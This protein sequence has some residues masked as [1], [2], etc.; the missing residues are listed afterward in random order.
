LHAEGRLG[1]PIGVGRTDGCRG[2]V[3]MRVMTETR[4]LRTR[5]GRVGPGCR[6]QFSTR[7]TPRRLGA[8]WVTI[9]FNGNSVLLPELAGPAPPV[10]RP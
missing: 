2:I 3:T 9:R 1:L 7:R 10:I 6:F 8:P 5:R 4:L